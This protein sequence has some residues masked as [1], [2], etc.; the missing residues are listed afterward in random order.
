MVGEARAGLGLDAGVADDH[1]LLIHCAA[2]TRFDLSDAD[3]NATNVTGVTNAIE[4]ARA[5][6][7][8][9]LHISNA[10]V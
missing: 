1:D 3:Y 2:T 7:M 8:A 6:G 4:V 10:Y 5:A 9:F